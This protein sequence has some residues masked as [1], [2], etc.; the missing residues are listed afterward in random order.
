MKKFILTLIAAAIS[1][2]PAF[3]QRFDDIEQQRRHRVSLSYNA[4]PFDLRWGHD[5]YNEPR[6]TYFSMTAVY[7]YRVEPWLEVGIDARFQY[8][9]RY[10]NSYYH[11]DSDKEFYLSLMP[12]VR[13]YWV[14][15]RNASAYSAVG[16]GIKFTSDR[17]NDTNLAG[18][19]VLIGVSVGRNRWFGYAEVGYISSVGVGFRF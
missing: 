4:I 15:G 8:H 3:G 6:R 7:A 11:N 2:I 9:A 17:Y 19:L 18:N 10:Y 13:F 14:R 1:A 16:L 12:T 5:V